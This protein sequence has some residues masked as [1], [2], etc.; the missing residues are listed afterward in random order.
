MISR[1]DLGHY[2]IAPFPNM[3]LSWI[4]DVDESQTNHQLLIG[5][6]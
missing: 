6:G 1:L 3:V 2:P 4:G 5:L